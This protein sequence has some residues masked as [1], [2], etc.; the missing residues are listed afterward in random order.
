MKV[1]VPYIVQDPWTTERKGLRWTEGFDIEGEEVFLDGPVTRRI[2]VLDF[3]E[4]TGALLPGAPFEPPP[5]R[6]KLGG[7]RLASGEPP[8][9][10]AAGQGALLARDFNQVSAFAT[11]AK[12][13]AMFESAD[14][15]GRPISWAF[16]GAQL[17]VVPRAGPG[18]NAAYERE[19]RSI[20]FFSFPSRAPDSRGEMVHTSLSQDVVSHET[21]HAV[22]DAVAPDLYHALTPQSLALHEAL[23]D[24]AALVMSFRCATLRRG[25]LD[26]TGGSIRDS[27]AF[28]AIAEQFGGARDAR[29][30]RRWL[31]SLLN[32]RTLDPDDDSVD[33]D[34]RPNRLAIARR[35]DPHDLSE[36]LSGALYTV[37]VGIHEAVKAERVAATGESE[38]S[39]SGWALAVA[40][41]RFK[42]MIFRALDYLPPGEIT[43]GDYGRAIVAADA[44]S[45]PDDDDERQALRDEFV[46]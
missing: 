33:D 18:A 44:A 19:S 42:R 27:T 41:E 37:M 45:H 17:L 29:G 23:A 7:Y 25:V 43:F 39:A 4:G 40:A 36:V 26:A 12:T 6:R 34:G 14:T 11:V 3:D 16:D 8:R 35:V 2:A 20:Q 32:G 22:L 10:E 1:R 46:R 9:G 15:L 21:G 13:L 28:C 31:R 38:H 30:E 5:P 24:L